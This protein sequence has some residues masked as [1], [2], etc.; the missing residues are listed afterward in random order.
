MRI[1]AND[2]IAA[3]AKAALE[4]KGFTVITEKA[5]QDDLIATLND[6]CYETLLVRSATKVTREV[7]ES[8]SNL[9]LIG[10]AGV[11][12]DNIDLVAAEE[13]EVKVF[14]TPSS[15]S[16]AVAELVIAS[17]FTLARFLNYSNRE[18]PVQGETE[19]SV[20]KKAYSKGFELRGKTIGILG[21]G[22]IG[23]AVAQ[24]A[25]GIGMKVIASD[26]SNN[27]KKSI[28]FDVAGVSIQCDIPLVSKSELL[29]KSDIITLH[30]PAQKDG[31]VLGEKEFDMMSNTACLINA[32]RGGVI[33]ESALL[34]A[35]NN[36]KLRAAALDV[37][38]TEPKPSKEI[39]S[40]PR[41]S[42]TP[43]T[44]AATVEAQQRIGEELVSNILSFYSK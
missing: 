10:R 34:N 8:C 12:L 19:F 42:L 9:K 22:R 39:I 3:D 23:Q 29:S 38:E 41:I 30:I 21:F 18:M 40:H 2:G 6:E 1:L 26:R 36:N 37:F 27:S 25:L 4:A 20:L 15:S 5:P 7:L 11:G 31:Y 24:Y 13:C 17:A 14:N 32:A 43:H 35:L 33:D 44:G 28:S 16:Q